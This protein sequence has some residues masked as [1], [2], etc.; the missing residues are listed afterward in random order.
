MEIDFVQKKEP[1]TEV[2]TTKCKIK[3]LVIPRATVDPGANFAIISKD[4]AKRLKLEIDMK[5]NMTLEDKYEKQE[6]DF[7]QKRNKW[8]RDRKKWCKKLEEIVSEN[9]NLQ[10]ENA[11]KAIS[12]ANSKSENITKSK[13]IRSLE[14]MIKI[15]ESKLFSAQKDVFS[16]Q[17]NSSNKKSEVLSL[18]SK[19]TE[20][21]RKLALNI[22]ELERLKSKDMSVSIV[23]GNN[24]KNITNS[25]DI[26]AVNE[27]SKNLGQYFIHRKSMD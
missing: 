9:Q 11:S 21:E 23:G 27:F 15:L 20:L 18:K 2:V 17:K 5:E 13:R 4:I 10:F 22:S 25:N 7:N 6:K 19:I 14:S 1:A 24:E 12:L 8:D 16:I 26:F 3:H